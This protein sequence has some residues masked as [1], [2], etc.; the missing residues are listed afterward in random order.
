MTPKE[1]GR[2]AGRIFQNTLPHNLVARDQQDQEDYGIDYE[3][4]AMLPKDKA[5]GVIF[6]VQ[7]KGT[8]DLKVNAAGDQVSFS[9]LDTER[10]RYYLQDLRIPAALVVVDVTNRGVYW[11]RLQGNAEAEAAYRA[12]AEAGQKTM[13]VHLPVANKLPATLDRFLAE[14][15][16]SQDAVM[17]RYLREI[18]SQ[19]VLEAA[20]SLPNFE[21]TLR[22]ARAHADTLRLQQVEM[23]LRAGDLQ[24]AVAQCRRILP[25]ESETVEV[26]LAAGLNLVRLVP[27]LQP[28][29]RS[30][31]QD[32]ALVK[33]RL[34]T[35]GKMLSLTEGRAANDRLRLFAE[36]QDHIAKVAAVTNHYA[37]LL[38]APRRRIQTPEEALKEVVREIAQRRAVVE[39]IAELQEAFARLEGLIRSG[40]VDM[41]AQA[42]AMLVAD[43]LVFVHLARNNGYGALTNGLIAWADA[44]LPVAVSFAEGMQDWTSV[45]FCA[46][47][48]IPLAPLGDTQEIDRRADIARSYINR[49]PVGERQM[50]LNELEARVTILKEQ[51]PAE[52]GS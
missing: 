46:L 4:E 45:A 38:D 27:V 36:L 3:I 15:V 22:A 44:T 13:T 29:P 40:N 2:E 52:V 32:R 51:P 18:S 11:A 17:V 31:E 12:A 50:H 24:G 10:M 14:M 43:V 34:E 30:A 1:I 49:I 7:E 6:K 39:I 5:S 26:R 21:A 9:E 48:I 19:K 35:T 41:V 8:T 23:R 28:P 33:G 25:S 16:K 47:Q 20:T 42:W 37:D